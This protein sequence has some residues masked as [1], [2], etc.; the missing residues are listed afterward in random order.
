MTGQQRSPVRAHGPVSRRSL[1]RATAAAGT[2]VAATPLISRY[3]SAQAR[4]VRVFAWAGY[5]NDAML[6]DFEHKTG[7]HA[8]YT[9]YDSN[10]TAFNQLRASGGRYE[11]VEIRDP[12]PAVEIVKAHER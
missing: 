12:H 5:L 6:Q 10:D 7:I 9:P 11:L 3:A 2:F 4:T 8:V 1:L